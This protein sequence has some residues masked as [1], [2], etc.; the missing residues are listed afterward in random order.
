ME[1]AKKEYIHLRNIKNEGVEEEYGNQL[2]PEG[3][4][5]LWL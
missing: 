5:L 4:V 1:D 3:R 2:L